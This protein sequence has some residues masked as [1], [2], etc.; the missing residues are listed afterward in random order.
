[1]RLHTI[2]RKYFLGF[3]DA[4]TKKYLLWLNHPYDI[5]QVPI[6]LG[7]NAG[8]YKIMR[9]WLEEGLLGE[10]FRLIYESKK[11]ADEPKKFKMYHK[12]IGDY[13]LMKWRLSPDVISIINNKPIGTYDE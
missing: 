6:L 3:N 5:K 7:R 1:M 2:L 8:Q 13:T 11:L 12:V 9:D 10:Y 4:D